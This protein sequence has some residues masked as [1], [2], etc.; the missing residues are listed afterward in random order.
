MKIDRTVRGFTRV[1]FTDR[2]GRACS[3]QHSSLTQPTHVWLGCDEIGLRRFEPGIGWS[4]VELPQNKSRG[5]DYIANNRMHLD[6]ETV[7]ELLPFLTRFAET[8]ELE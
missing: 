2:S 7:R 3:L 1:E 4:D 5:V 8:G 6:R